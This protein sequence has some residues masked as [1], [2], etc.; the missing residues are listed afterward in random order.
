MERMR[1]SCRSASDKGSID[2]KLS[3]NLDSDALL[4]IPMNPSYFI[5][6]RHPVV[7]AA[8]LKLIVTAIPLVAQIN[9][10]YEG[11]LDRDAPRGV[12]TIKFSV[13]QNRPSEISVIPRHLP[14]GKYRNN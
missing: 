6:Q 12:D 1:F 10:R 8:A 4:T 9:D 14:F 3:S 13:P 2:L 7:F 11:S 5:S